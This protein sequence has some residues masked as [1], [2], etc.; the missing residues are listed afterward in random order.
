MPSQHDQNIQARANPGKPA[1]TPRAPPIE[2]VNFTIR[3]THLLSA[4]GV[5][6][7]ALIYLRHESK[8]DISE[9]KADLK[10]DISEL[11]AEIVG[12]RTDIQAAL[13]ALN[14]KSGEMNAHAQFYRD[15]R[16]RRW[17]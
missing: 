5:L 8:A 12:I 11:K 2:N 10:A 4:F 1:S 7:G 15:S 17:W 6:T 16:E 9:L 3:L 14:V 13:S